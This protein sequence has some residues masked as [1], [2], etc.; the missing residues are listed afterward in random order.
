VVS[1]VGTAVELA[2]ALFVVAVAV[3]AARAGRPLTG[4]TLGAAAATRLA[5]FAGLP[6]A[7]LLAYVLLVVAIVAV[8]REAAASSKVSRP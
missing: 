4:A 3:L 8:A 6:L 1:V 7:T 2:A 5:G